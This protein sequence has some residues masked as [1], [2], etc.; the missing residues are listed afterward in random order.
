MQIVAIA[1]AAEAVGA[2]EKFVADADAPFRSK[3]RDIGNFLEM[4]ILGV[5]AADDHGE[6]VF[7]TER[8]GDFKVKALGI[9]GATF[10]ETFS[11]RSRRPRRKSARS[12]RRAAGIAP[13]RMSESLTSATPRKMKVPSPP[14]PMAAAM[15]ATP[16]VMMV[17][18]RMP[19][20]ITARASGKRT[21]KRICARVMPM[22]SAA[23]STAGSIPVRPT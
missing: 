23:S 1:P 4:E 2:L 22:A 20:R 9:E 14:A 3:G 11:F 16:I 17:A 5:V 6:S 13:A 8:L 21:R 19:A 18:V 7:K 12:A 10:Q 15:V